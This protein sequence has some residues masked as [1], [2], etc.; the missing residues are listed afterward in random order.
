M[1]EGCAAP[2]LNCTEPDWTVSAP[3]M[4]FVPLKTSVPGPNFVKLLAVNLPESVGLEPP[5]NPVLV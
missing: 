3:V 1:D 2:P 4:R 5:V